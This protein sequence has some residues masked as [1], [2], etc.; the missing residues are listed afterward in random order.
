[1]GGQQ[2]T[3]E[4]SRLEES[5][6]KKPRAFFPGGDGSG[7]SP[8]DMLCASTEE[9]GGE[10]DCIWLWLQRS[11]SARTRIDWRIQH[12]SFPLSSQEQPDVS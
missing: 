2:A 8:V 7:R 12:R 3:E 6:A 1:M 9:A 4:P 11:G 10:N 5:R